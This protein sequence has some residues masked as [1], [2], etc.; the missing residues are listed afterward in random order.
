M[1]GVRA[2]IGRFEEAARLWGAADALRG[3]DA[4]LTGELLLVALL[5]ERLSPGL[6]DRLAGRREE[7]RLL[8][9]ELVL[10]DPGA[11]VGIATPE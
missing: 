9:R 2:V 6:G 4:L 11:V 10:R 3:D 8:D 1:A 7:G 5:E